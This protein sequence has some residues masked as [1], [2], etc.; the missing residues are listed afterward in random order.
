MPYGQ[1]RFKKPFWWAA[2]LGAAF[3]IPVSLIGAGLA[4]NSRFSGTNTIRKNQAKVWHAVLCDI[5]QQVMHPDKSLDQKPLTPAQ[6]ERVLKY[7]D[8]LIVLAGA[9]PCDGRPHG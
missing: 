9:Q 6:K 8:H 2:T 7:Y 3:F 5:E 4:L 1:A